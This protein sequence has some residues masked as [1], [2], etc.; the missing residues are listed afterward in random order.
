M[1]DSDDITKEGRPLPYLSNTEEMIALAQP[2]PE[3][4]A[5]KNFPFYAP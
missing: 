1:W 4:W 5:S 3:I 2:V